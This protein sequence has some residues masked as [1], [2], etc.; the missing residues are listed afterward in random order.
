MIMKVIKELHSLNPE[1]LVRSIPLIVERR[2]LA[3]RRWRGKAEDGTDF[4]FD[5]D[6]PLRH[7][8]CFHTENQKKYVI[9]QNKIH[10]F[11][12]NVCDCHNK[13]CDSNNNICDSQRKY[14]ILKTKYLILTIL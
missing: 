3:K 5:L 9:S 7:G 1:I 14:A 6:V 13:A 2:V 4:G 10:D 8:I 11:E 12:N